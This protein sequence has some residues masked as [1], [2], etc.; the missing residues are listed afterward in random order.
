[1]MAFNARAVDVPDPDNPAVGGGWT[2]ERWI[3]TIGD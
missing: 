1:M 3:G 2:E